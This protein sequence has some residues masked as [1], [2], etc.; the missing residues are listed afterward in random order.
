MDSFYTEK[1]L[2]NIGFKKMGTNIKISRKASIYSP[3][4]MSF[5]N[6]IR[7]DDFCLLNGTIELENNIYIAGFTA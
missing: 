2:E 5:G 3:E 6:N 1:E 7:I 4:K